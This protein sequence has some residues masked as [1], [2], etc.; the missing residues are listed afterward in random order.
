MSHLHNKVREKKILGTKQWARS[1]G[2]LI[3]IAKTIKFTSQS[4][5]GNEKYQ[6][7]N[8]CRHQC[9]AEFP[10]YQICGNIL[11]PHSWAISL[12]L[13]FFLD[14]SNERRVGAVSTFLH[15]VLISFQVSDKLC[16]HSSF[17]VISS[18]LRDIRP[19]SED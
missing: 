11:P 8:G 15:S 5:A 12:I 14:C 16:V 6:L 4:M 3:K 18:S 2:K 9:T 13:S 7:L 17:T 10:A 19:T 1:A